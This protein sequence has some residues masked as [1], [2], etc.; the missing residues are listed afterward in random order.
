MPN[1]RRHGRARRLRAPLGAGS[2]ALVLLAL[3]AHPAA[4]QPSAEAQPDRVA[5]GAPVALTYR[6]SAPL[7]VDL[8]IQERVTCE[9]EAPDGARGPLCDAPG[10]LVRVDVAPGETTY[11]FTV[12]APQAPG[13][14]TI[15]F[16]RARTLDLLGPADPSA[17]VTLVVATDAPLAPGGGPGAG[18]GGAGDGTEEGA[19]PAGPDAPD[20][21]D[22]QRWLVST[23]MGTAALVVMLVGG[24]WGL[25]GVP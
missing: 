6:V 2:L 7:P 18:D 21:L 1:D 5:P 8:G 9:I 10:A 16:T 4:A 13:T 15:H 12:A 14:Y 22:A 25:G 19:S 24:R 11:A 17:S 23:A 3:L 20:G